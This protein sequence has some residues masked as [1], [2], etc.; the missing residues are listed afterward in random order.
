MIFMVKYLGG[1]ILLSTI[2]FETKYRMKQWM[3]R[4]SVSART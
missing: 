1:S 3:D 2:Y 4:W